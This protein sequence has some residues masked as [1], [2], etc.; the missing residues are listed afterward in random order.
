MVCYQD[1]AKLVTN[2]TRDPGFGLIKLCFTVPDMTAALSRLKEHQVPIL[3]E[4]G[5]TKGLDLVAGGLGIS[6]DTS[7]NKLVWD[8]IGPVVFAQDPDE[9]VIELIQQ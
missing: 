1:P 3:K 5:A 7:I 2:T 9:Y 4:P 8:A 6:T